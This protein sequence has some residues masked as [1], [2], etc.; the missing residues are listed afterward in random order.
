MLTVASEL[1]PQHGV[2]TN[3]YHRVDRDPTRSIQ[4]SASP[5]DRDPRTIKIGFDPI[6]LLQLDEGG[7]G[8][9][10]IEG[11]RVVDA[12]VDPRNRSAPER[13]AQEGGLAQHL[14]GDGAGVDHRASG[15]PLGLDHR[16]PVAAIARQHR[17]SFTSERSSFNSG[18]RSRCSR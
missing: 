9:K 15:Q 14:R 4:S 8:E 17:G 2:L 12:G 13:R 16:H 3:L 11:D 7:A 10:T 6:V 18:D 5:E 1:L